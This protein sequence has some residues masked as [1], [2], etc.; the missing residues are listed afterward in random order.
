MTDKRE[1]EEKPPEA[2]V[3]QSTAMPSD[4]PPGAASSLRDTGRLP[5]RWKLTEG[6]I[7]LLEMAMS[8]S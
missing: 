3:G 4:W 8:T 1:T 2:G 6:E 7:T 5:E